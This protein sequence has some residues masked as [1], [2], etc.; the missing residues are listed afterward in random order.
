MGRVDL[1]LRVA[2]LVQFVAGSW[3]LGTRRGA[4]FTSPL[5]LLG[6]IGIWFSISYMH[7]AAQVDCLTYVTIYVAHAGAVVWRLTRK[8]EDPPAQ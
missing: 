1:W 6:V 2:G 4:L 3:A 5:L 7:T 8:P